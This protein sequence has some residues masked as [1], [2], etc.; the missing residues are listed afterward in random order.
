M[1]M[2]DIPV[3]SSTP[4]PFNKNLSNI[5]FEEEKHKLKSRMSHSLTSNAF[6][7]M[8]DPLVVHRV[9]SKVPGGET[10]QTSG[11]QH[12][13]FGTN[14]RAMEKNYVLNV[15]ALELIRS[16]AAFTPARGQTFVTFN[17]IYPAIIL[18][19]FFCQTFLV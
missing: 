9:L 17:D 8:K 19:H 1:P 15:K 7:G 13:P 14:P 3:K 11:S 5:K 12:L 2:Q 18:L 16:S 4:T 6:P 10:S